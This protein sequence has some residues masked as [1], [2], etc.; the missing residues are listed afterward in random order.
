MV[1]E[2]CGAHDIFLNMVKEMK[3]SQDKISDEIG[4]S[5]VHSAMVNL[6]LETLSQQF[7]AYREENERY[8]SNFSHRIDDLFAA[9]QREKARSKFRPTHLVAIITALLGTVGIITAAWLNNKGIRP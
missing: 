3:V 4:A 9:I 2:T 8:Q 6:K 7:A 5:N 1:H